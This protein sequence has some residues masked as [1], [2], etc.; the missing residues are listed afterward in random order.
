MDELVVAARGELDQK[1]RA[2]MYKEIQLIISR[3]GATIVPAYGRDVA[4][5]STR[6]GTTGQYGGGWEMDGGHYIKR[7]WLKS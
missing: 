6:V 7:W 5:L 3:D 1:K 4:A 2:E